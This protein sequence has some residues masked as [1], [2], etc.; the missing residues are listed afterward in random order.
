MRATIATK[1]IEQVMKQRKV[2][3]DEIHEQM[4]ERLKGL[5]IWL[6]TAELTEVYLVQEQLFRDMQQKFRDNQKRSAQLYHMKIEENLS[7]L[8]TAKQLEL[9]ALTDSANLELDKYRQASNLRIQDQTTQD[10]QKIA[11]IQQQIYEAQQQHKNNQQALQNKINI[12]LQEDGQQI[13]MKTLELRTE[14]L[15][16]ETAIQNSEF[17]TTELN[18]KYDRE[19]KDKEKKLEQEMAGMETELNKEALDE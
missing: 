2:I 5:G 1:T 7:K 13:K 11:T 8:R 18:T 19:T 3:R 15:A 12:M 16:L 9:K 10:Q 14:R 6:E 4:M 17:K